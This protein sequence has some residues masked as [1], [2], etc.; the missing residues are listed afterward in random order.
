ME[1]LTMNQLMDCSPKLIGE[2]N[3]GRLQVALQKIRATL[4]AIETRPE[5]LSAGLDDALK[6]LKSWRDNDS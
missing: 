6:Q 5:M 2:I 1:K 3:V 4:E